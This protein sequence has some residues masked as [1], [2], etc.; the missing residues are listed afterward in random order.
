MFRDSGNS[1]MEKTKFGVGSLVT[2]G[3]KT[4]LVIGTGNKQVSIMSLD[5]FETVRKPIEV[6][7]INFL[8]SA[9]ARE[10]IDSTVGD[11]LQYTFTDFDL[12][13][14]GVKFKDFIKF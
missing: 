3:H 9:E 1:A 12:I 14:A 10:L 13:P 6:V 5:T 11:E 8:T 7:D 2:T 4:F